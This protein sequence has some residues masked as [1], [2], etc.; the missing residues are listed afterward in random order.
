MAFSGDLNQICHQ[1]N[2]D[3]SGCR[4]CVDA[5]PFLQETGDVP[6]EIARRR[7][8]VREAF[9][10]TLCGLCEALCPLGLSP[11]AMFWAARHHGVLTGQIDI[12]QYR[13]LFPDR[14]YT[15]MRYYREFYGIRYDH[16]PCDSE[17]PN[18]LFPGCVL[19]TYAPALVDGLYHH[20]QGR[21]G[22]LSLLTD[23]CGLPLAQL[24]MEDRFRRYDETLRQ[25]L[26]RL[27]VKHLYIACPNCYYLLQGNL[28]KSGIKLFTVYEGLDVARLPGGEN[29]VIAVHDSC[30]DRHEGIFATQVRT[31]LESKGYVIEELPH[32][33]DLSL[34]C[35]SGGQVTHL[36]PDLADG[37]LRRH[38]QEFAQSP[39]STVVA[40]CLGCVLNFAKNSGT[41]KIQ[42]AL[43]LLLGLDQDFTGVKA[44][45]AELF[46]GP[47]GEAA[48]QKIMADENEK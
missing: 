20:L 43:N 16:L 30:P 22:S 32:R 13:Y 41:K 34:C 4:Q 14:E 2:Q 39:A 42:H 33:R 40:Y 25:K 7:P 10:C 1:I 8:S 24:G 5:C 19:L 38:W 45:A 47:A 28:A 12:N 17:S 18:A 6:G 26:H 29:Q 9:S 21:L 3:C 46:A 27:R 36:R 15:V 11:K 37:L 48:W 44:K 31:A 35:G 23:C